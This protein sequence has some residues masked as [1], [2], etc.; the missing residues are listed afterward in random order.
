MDLQP[1]L[2]SE[3]RKLTND[4]RELQTDIALI[5]GKF[6][7]EYTDQ[8]N[9]L[10]LGEHEWQT[11]KETVSNS[12][13]VMIEM[14]EDFL[15]NRY[16]R[17][18]HWSALRLLTAS[19]VLSSE[20]DAYQRKLGYIANNPSDKSK[21]VV[22]LRDYFSARLQPTGGKFALRMTQLLS[23]VL[24]PH[25]WSVE[26]DLTH[27]TGEVSNVRLRLQFQPETKVRRAEERAR[28]KQLKRIE[29]DD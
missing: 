1:W 6:Q 7:V 8:E 9:T 26:A 27:A 29:I 25:R 4:I 5:E 12:C 2:V 19:G 28:L 16:Q 15:D 22:H 11:F 10:P 17:Q 24:D 3:A 18:L 14:L 23:R 20:I 13:M 21:S